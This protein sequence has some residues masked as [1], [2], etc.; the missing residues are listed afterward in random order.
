M[1]KTQS[2]PKPE[3]ANHSSF[4]TKSWG[5]SPKIRPLSLKAVNSPARM[6]LVAWIILEPQQRI[7]KLMGRLYVVRRYFVMER[8]FRGVAL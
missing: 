4:I 6:T 1:S 2:P 3:L 7:A 5:S 8:T